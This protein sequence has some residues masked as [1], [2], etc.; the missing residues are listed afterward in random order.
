MQN[1][2]YQR[3]IGL[4]FGLLIIY[5]LEITPRNSLLVSENIILPNVYSLLLIVIMGV[6]SLGFG[7]GAAKIA[8]LDRSSSTTPLAKL[9]LSFTLILCIGDVVLT[10]SPYIN[11]N[12]FRWLLPLIFIFV[13]KNFSAFCKYFSD[14]FVYKSTFARGLWL[15][16]LVLCFVMILAFTILPAQRSSDVVQLYVPM[17]D[18]FRDLK[19]S[20]SDPKQGNL[21]WYF[22]TRGRGLDI[23]FAQEFGA[24]L[25]TFVSTLFLV[26]TALTSATLA[27]IIMPKPKYLTFHMRLIPPLIAISVL[28]TPA[29]PGVIGRFHAESF[30]VL[31]GL[32][33]SVAIILKH[34][35][36]LAVLLSIFSS[37]LIILQIPVMTIYVSSIWLFFAL[38]KI[39]PNLRRIWPISGVVLSTLW[40]LI[41]IILNVRTVGIGDV[42]PF[43]IFKH[44][45]TSQLQSWT[46]VEYLE[47]LNDSQ[48]FSGIPS[49]FAL[50]R[51]EFLTFLYK[52]P[53]LVAPF[54]SQGE[55]I[56]IVLT[57]LL[58]LTLSGANY[59]KTVPVERYQLQI[60]FLLLAVALSWISLQT[61]FSS[62]SLER[63]L[64]AQFS[65][66]PIFVLSGSLII[67]QSKFS[68]GVIK[69]FPN[70][71]VSFLV[72]TSLIAI[73]NSASSTFYSLPRI[74]SL[75]D[76]AIEA[77]SVI[78]ETGGSKNQSVYEPYFDLGICNR[79]LAG[80][81][82]QGRI[83]ILNSA[84]L[85]A[86]FC[87]AQYKNH[88]R[89]K[90]V[91]SLDVEISRNFASIMSVNEERVRE[92]FDRA[93][94]NHVVILRNDFSFFG[95][96]LSPI[97]N[98]R[99]LGANLYVEASSPEFYRLTFNQ[100]QGRRLNSEEIAEISNLRNLAIK[101]TPYTDGLVK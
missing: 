3:F 8:H 13:I 42:S 79:I 99:F 34:D 39:R 20:G 28:L 82:V 4:T 19:F 26:S 1:H 67:S 74:H 12:S 61:L 43:Q 69:N 22:L 62:G 81:N 7:C 52:S 46:S 54:F 27:Q 49:T 11:F 88:R 66:I 41:V 89:V 70:L 75:K 91:D 21:W 83:L 84:T 10:L 15:F 80:S 51:S 97:F 60:S 32:I 63:L 24:D 77:I 56:L 44:S 78:I 58:L 45:I 40:G 18:A 16:F 17:L 50:L 86:P 25:H 93:G 72:L 2:R 92:A 36:T 5:F 9:S 100:N 38:S 94:I 73:S 59:F 87:F 85:H 23:F 6:I 96:G 57:L 30:A 101:L 68:V 64:F 14:F 53:L 98:S 55:L 71:M 95:P 31:M 29:F 90:F 48:G 35:S 33:L 47:Y 76:R 37:M 65:V